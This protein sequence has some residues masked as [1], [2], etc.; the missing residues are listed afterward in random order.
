[1]SML[2]WATMEVIFNG[3]KWFAGRSS[4][5][6]AASAAVIGLV[7]VTPACGYVTAMSALLIGFVTAVCCFFVPRGVRML[8]I[9]DRLD[10]FA[11]HGVGGIVGSLLT[12]LLADKKAGSA[13]DGG[14][15]LFGKQIAAL[16]AAILL[17][18][19]MTTLIFFVLKAVAW[20]L[21][22]EVGI[23][24]EQQ[25]DVDRSQHG[26]VAYFKATAKV[27][28]PLPAAVPAPADSTTSVAPDPTNAHAQVVSVV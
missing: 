7:G 5:V 23:P 16:L 3:D 19:V 10:V 20:V 8:G 24:Q 14:G 1:M 12:G 25:H 15:E 28:A 22:T 26:E 2:T 11:F 18:V 21:K 13:V 17:S 4:A 6:G 9:D 27:A